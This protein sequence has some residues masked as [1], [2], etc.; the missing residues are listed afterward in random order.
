MCG[1]ADVRMLALI[2]QSGR[3]GADVRMC[4]CGSLWDANLILILLAGYDMI[5]TFVSFTIR[6]FANSHIR[7]FDLH[8]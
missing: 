6:T 5:S 8:G 1:C 4:G 2:P 3:M 7:T